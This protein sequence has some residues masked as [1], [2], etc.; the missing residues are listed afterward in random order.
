L[1]NDLTNFLITLVE[2]MKFHEEWELGFLSVVGEV[3]EQPGHEAVPPI[4]LYTFMVC[5]GMTLPIVQMD[6]VFWMYQTV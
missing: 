4:L 6:V 1:Y 5:T 3:T 2:N